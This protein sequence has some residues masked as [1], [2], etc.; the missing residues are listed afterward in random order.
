MSI[1]Q[2]LYSAAAALASSKYPVGWA[3]A[4]AIRTASGKILTSIAPVVTNDALNLC[5]EVGAYL[6]AEKLGEAITHSLC[7]FRDNENS[8]F[9]VLTPCGICQERL[10]RWGGAVLAAISN[11][12]NQLLFKPLREL[13]PHHWSLVDGKQL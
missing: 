12:S 7:I 13:C 10:L 8:P 5:M 2:D 11:P 4:A 6:E 3:G 1:E 9:L